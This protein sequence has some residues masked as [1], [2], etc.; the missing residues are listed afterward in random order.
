MTFT[1]SRTPAGITLLLCLSLLAGCNTPPAAPE[2]A[3]P[4][5]PTPAEM[6]SLLAGS[7][8][9]AA[10]AMPAITARVDSASAPTALTLRDI[11]LKDGV[12]LLGATVNA[13]LT[14]PVNSGLR[15]TRLVL[16]LTPTPLMPGATLSLSQGGRL[17]SQHL[18]TDTTTQVTLPLTDLIVD[19][20]RAT[21]M[22]G[23]RIGDIEVCA[24]EVTYRTAVQPT[25]RIEY[26]GSPLPVGGINDFFAPWLSRVVFYLPDEPSLDAA[27][28]ALDAAAFVNRRYRGMTTRFEILPLPPEGTA[29]SEPAADERA[30][31][32]SPSGPT[33]VVRPGGGRGTVMA[34]AS[35]RDARQLFALADG[36]QLVPVGGFSATTVRPELIGPDARGTLSFGEMGLG[37][38][39]VEGS[40]VIVASYPFS[41]ADFG[42]QV[43]PRAVRLL[44]HHSML[45]QDGR[46]TMRVTLNGQ[47]IE[48]VRLDRTEVD[49]T[50]SLPGHLLARENRLDVRF[51]VVLGEGRCMLGGP[52]FAATIDDRSTFVLTGEM[53]LPP[54]F[55]RFPAA[56]VPAF[57]VLME[58]RDRFRVE[59]AARAVGAMQ[60][61]TTTALAPFVVRDRA[62][63]RGSLLAIGN[64]TL[65]TE[66]DAPIAGD[67]FRLRDLQGRVWDEYAPTESFAAMQAYS[68]DGRD[69]LLLH[70]TRDDGAPLDAMLRESLAAYGWFGV[71]G[72][73]A[74]RGPDGPTT[75]ITAAN[76]GWIIDRTV[77]DPPTMWE[78][79]R[80]VIFIAAG[81]TLLILA[82]WLFPRVVRRE[83]DTTG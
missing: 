83:L 20:G 33:M 19:A 80:S 56:F 61:T 6:D 51:H 39:T 2:V 48:S 34:L 46:G 13:A 8:D 57:S 72:D 31:F 5:A 52:T 78:R 1:T 53:P 12:T 70:H 40:S 23:L 4:A 35:R 18:L 28:A 10:A 42:R 36:S 44:V 62:E 68:A 50:V 79:W 22:L 41:L 14:I 66:L 55:D 67:G 49:R 29:L 58:P 26:A 16:D 74:L 76:S 24:A 71:H 38:E 69:I 60:Q 73:L 59:L 37:A 54:S 17:L 30:L 15:P 27:Q 9:S 45:P 11:G 64:S 81:L 77:A 32:W 63:V 75:V 7:G 3:G 65:A 47:L 25:S 82:I 43:T 21:V